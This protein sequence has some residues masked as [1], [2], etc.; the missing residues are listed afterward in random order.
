MISLASVKEIEAAAYPGHMQ[1]LQDCEDWEDVADYAECTRKN[2]LVLGEEG[3]W[4][5]LIAR[6]ERCRGRDAE[7]VDLAKLP[8]SARVPWHRLLQVLQKM[9]IR[10]VTLD[11]REGTS[12]EILKVLLPRWGCKILKDANWEWDGETMHNMCIVLP[13]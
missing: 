10:R 5:A 3:H 4:Y 11:A 1:F 13:A 12:Y 7:F 8:G 2:L 9:K 6:K